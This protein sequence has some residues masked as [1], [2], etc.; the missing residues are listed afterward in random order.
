MEFT[1]MGKT[2]QRNFS[3]LQERPRQN[4]GRNVAKCKLD[5]FIRD[6]E[7]WIIES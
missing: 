7:D 1:C 6:Q 5:D 4:Y 3:Q 2:E